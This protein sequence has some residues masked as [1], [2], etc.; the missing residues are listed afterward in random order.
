MVEPFAL[1]LRER[2]RLLMVRFQIL[3]HALGRWPSGARDAEWLIATHAADDDEVRQGYSSF[4]RRRASRS[5]SSFAAWGWSFWAAA[6][7]YHLS[8]SCSSFGTY[9]PTSWQHPCKDCHRSYGKPRTIHELLR[10]A[11]DRDNPAGYAHF[12]VVRGMCVA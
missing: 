3:I 1:L 7:R 8:A 12:V 10:L 5:A 4:A 6:L 2:D 9:W 11:L